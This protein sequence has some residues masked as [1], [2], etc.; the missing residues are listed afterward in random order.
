MSDNPTLPAAESYRPQAT[1]RDGRPHSEE[2]ELD[3]PFEVAGKWWASITVRRVTAGEV[4]AFTTALKEAREAGKPLDGIRLPMVEAPDEVLALL[5]PD[6]EDRVEEAVQRFLPR[7]F[8]APEA[9]RP[10]QATGEGS[11]PA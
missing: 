6:D 11:S 8:R 9:P 5:D 2:V 7:R 1:S 4:E 3:W 10:A